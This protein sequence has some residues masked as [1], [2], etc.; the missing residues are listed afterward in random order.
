MYSKQPFMTIINKTETENQHCV[1]V[2]I[3]NALHK[4]SEYSEVFHNF[5]QYSHKLSCI[6]NNNNT[7]NYIW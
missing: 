2:Y 3:H 7:N 5:L 6:Y 1:L 4:Y